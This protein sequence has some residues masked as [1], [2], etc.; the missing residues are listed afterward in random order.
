M[1][2]LHSIYACFNINT[3]Y[4]YEVRAGKRKLQKKKFLKFEKSLIET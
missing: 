1:H 4:V 3:Y 2:Y